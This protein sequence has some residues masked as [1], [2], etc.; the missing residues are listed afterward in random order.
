MKLIKILIYPGIFVFVFAIAAYLT[1]D[2]LLKRQ[3]NVICPDVRGRDIEEART[4][5]QDKGLSLDVVRYEKRNDI[6]YNHITV[7]KPEANISTRLGRTV[8]VIVS[9]GPELVSLPVLQGQR[10]IDAENILQE[11]NIFV[12]RVIY[13]PYPK[14]GIV[15]SQIPKG[16]EGILEG[17]GITLFVSL[18]GDSYYLMPDIRG[19]NLNDLTEEMTMKNIR[20]TVDF[21]GD[22]H[23]PLNSPIEAS[24]PARTIFGKDSGVEIKIKTGG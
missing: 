6:A 11:S 3:I 12:D 21:V 10:F 9:E 5:L 1:I 14:P 13:V 8:M 24:V 15:V 20:H 2:F 16:G 17:S 22:T 4:L 18:D 7:Q 19:L 23:S